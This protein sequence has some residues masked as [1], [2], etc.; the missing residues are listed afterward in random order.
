LADQASDG[1]EKTEEPTQ[2]RLEKAKEDGQVASSK[3][4]FV[5]STL[6]VGF[7]LYFGLL[8]FL[9]G[10]LL[11]WSAL[12][13]FS[14]EGGLHDE[15]IRNSSASFA[16]IFWKS[17]IFALPLLVIIVLTQMA[18]SGSINWSASALAFKGSRINP[19]NGLK[20]MF[21]VKALVEMLKAVAK[22]ASL[23][24]AAIF[25]FSS[26][27]DK[28]LTSQATHLFGALSRLGDVFVFLIIVFLLVLA[29]IAMFDVVY[30][31]Y[32][33]NKKL[34]MTLQELKDESKQTEGSPEVKAKIRRL[35]MTAGSRA[36]QRREAMEQVPS[37]TAIITNPIHFAVA[38]KYEIGTRGAPTILAMGRGHQAQ[39]II[40]IGK[41][42][43]V[44]VFSNELLPCLV[45]AGRIGDEIPPPL[46]TA[47]AA[48]LAFIYQLNKGEQIDEPDVDLPDDMLFDANGKSLS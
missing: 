36:K 27:V 26:E 15:I 34:K 39:E 24:G 1:Q 23:I 48:V 44:T 31:Q 7:L 37:A 4:L 32:E 13:R 30:Q 12:L 8:P 9:S 40:R 2:K 38:L 17:I 20:R 19:V 5:L 35:Q 18:M 47:V 11:E 43:G 46:Y 25:V 28:L 29:V 16:F 42:A 41:E 14:G 10:L 33:H 22:V 45:F 3:E 21:S 6:L